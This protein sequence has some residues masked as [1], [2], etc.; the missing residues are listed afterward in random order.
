MYHDGMDSDCRDVLKKKQTVLAKNIAFNV[1]LVA[2]CKEDLATI[3]RRQGG[4]PSQ[5]PGED[6]DRLVSHRTTVTNMK[7]REAIKKTMARQSQ[8]VQAKPNMA[9][10]CSQDMKSMCSDIADGAGRMHACLRKH[11]AEL[12]NEHCKAMVREVWKWEAES[13]H[14]NPM[15]HQSCGNELASFCPKIED[16]NSQALVCLWLHVRDSG[17]SSACRSAVELLKEAA[18]KNVTDSSN[19]LL[20]TSLA[21]GMT[22]TSLQQLAKA[23][24]TEKQTELISFLKTHRGFWDT[25]GV[26]ILGLLVVSCGVIGFLFVRARRKTIYDI[27]VAQDANEPAPHKFGA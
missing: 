16:R 21:G 22:N 17:F 12:K 27:E 9:K 25:W 8:D 6:I 15:V 14:L 2:N 18:S 5:A 23:L 11:M 10:E 1:G 19:S 13:I 3:K 24:A 4:P 26:R 7:C 20:L